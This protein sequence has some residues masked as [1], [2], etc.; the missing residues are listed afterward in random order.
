MAATHVPERTLVPTSLTSLL[1]LPASA[2]VGGEEVIYRVPGTASTQDGANS[3]VS[4]EPLLTST[5]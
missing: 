1:P 5:A 2:A 3:E 4:S